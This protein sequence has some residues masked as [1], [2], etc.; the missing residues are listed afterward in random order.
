LLLGPI[1]FLTLLG[2]WSLAVARIEPTH[3]A[4]AWQTGLTCLVDDFHTVRAPYPAIPPLR[5]RKV[6]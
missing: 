6:L 3:L 5:V 1:E 2:M 4:L